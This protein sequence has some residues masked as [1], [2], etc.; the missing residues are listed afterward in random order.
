M[1][2]EQTGIR[3]NHKKL[4]GKFKHGA[5]SNAA[6]NPDRVVKG[7]TSGVGST[8]R[9]KN[10]IKRLKMYDQKMPNKAKMY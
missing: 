4:H 9:T 2:K 3:A 8:L 7:N 6:T 5:K 10:T 1:A